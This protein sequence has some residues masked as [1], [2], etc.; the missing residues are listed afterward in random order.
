[1]K[2]HGWSTIIG[3]LAGLSIGAG[4]GE[5]VMGNMTL[6]LLIGSAMGAFIGSNTHIHRNY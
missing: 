4:I 5:T 6:G 1:M 2:E 3:I